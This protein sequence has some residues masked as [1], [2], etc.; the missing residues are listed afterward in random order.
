MSVLL[1]LHVNYYYVKIWITC[2][3]L[4]HFLFTYLKNTCLV[5]MA[6]MLEMYFWIPFHVAKLSQNALQPQDMIFCDM[7][8]RFL[9]VHV[10]VSLA[11]QTVQDIHFGCPT[12]FFHLLIFHQR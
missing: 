2:S 9:Q 6:F 8:M 3:V 5:L 11:S 10:F 4:L 12:A 7:D 1:V